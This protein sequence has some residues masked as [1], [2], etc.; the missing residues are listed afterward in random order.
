MATLTTVDGFQITFSSKAVSAITDHDG[1]TGQAVTCVYGITMGVL[2]ISEAVQAFMKRLGVTK[3]FAQLT[4]PNGSPV[5][6]NGS[7]VSSIRAP[8]P[9]EYVAGVNTVISAGSLTQGVEE[10]LADVT[11][12]INAY[13]G[14]L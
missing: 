6:I 12:A 9:N 11:T 2:D 8:L 14:D 3:N 1:S 5:W 10:T 13:G 4:R 7:S